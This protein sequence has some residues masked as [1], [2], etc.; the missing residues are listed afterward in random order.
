[1]ES[2]FIR[3]NLSRVK[4]ATVYLVEK[5]WS[6]LYTAYLKNIGQRELRSINN[7]RLF[8][9]RN[10]LR[11]DIREKEDYFIIN[12]RVWK[13]VQ[14]MYGGGPS[15]MQDVYFPVVQVT[16]KKQEVPLVGLVNP[17][18]LCFMIAVLQCL[19]T[20]QHFAQFMYKKYACRHPGCSRT[21]RRSSPSTAPST[22]S[23]RP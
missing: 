18:N 12:D 11:G 5:S 16:I 7:S 13:F 22:G 19:I 1:M 14:Q 4:T 21:P 2:E 17:L 20:N 23:S 3:Q 10:A 8:D 6:E 15:I 9:S